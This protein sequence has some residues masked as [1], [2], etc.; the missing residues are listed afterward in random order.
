MWAFAI[1]DRRRGVGREQLFVAR[2]RVGEKPFYYRLDSDRFEFS[3]EL[4]GIN[5][6]GGFDLNSLNHY[7]A[8]GYV[9]GDLCMAT[10]VKKLPPAHAG[11]FDLEQRSFH[12]WKYWEL[13]LPNH[14]SDTNIA[15]QDYAD[16]A[17]SLLTDSVRLR[18][19][20]DVPSGIFLSGGLT[21]VS[22][23]LRPLK[24]LPEQSRLLRLLC[25]APN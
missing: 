5:H 15:G 25:R 17:W 4:K 14:S 12:V 7:L 23:L 10:G 6:T 3:S 22:S 16:R 21:L 13:P 8:L 11:I 2:D 18:L 24:Y 20:S 1:F 19:R 9:P